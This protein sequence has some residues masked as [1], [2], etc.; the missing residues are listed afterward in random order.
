MELDAIRGYDGWHGA[1]GFGLELHE[2]RVSTEIVNGQEEL[3]VENIDEANM[4]GTAAWKRLDPGD[5]PMA[6]GDPDY[7]QSV[8]AFP[9]DCSGDSGD[10]DVEF[11]PC[12]NVQIET[13]GAPLAFN[14]PSTTG[15][16]F[17]D[18]TVRPNSSIAAMRWCQL[19]KL[20]LGQPP[21]TLTQPE[22]F[23]GTGASF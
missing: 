8:L 21:G 11:F 7:V 22:G 5:R 4:T 3:I 17:V 10:G 16:T 18:G 20:S 13:A 19:P 6:P 23:L 9:A 15:E 1:D 2:F 12:N 14:P